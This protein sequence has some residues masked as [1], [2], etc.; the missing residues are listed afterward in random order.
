MAIIDTK[1]IAAKASMKDSY[2]LKNNVRKSRR[3]PIA[4]I[5][6]DVM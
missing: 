6:V 1:A 4:K 2:A 3:V 5:L